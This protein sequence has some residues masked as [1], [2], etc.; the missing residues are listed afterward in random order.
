[1]IE[2]YSDWSP[3]LRSLAILASYA[4]QLLVG[5][6]AG[7]VALGAARAGQWWI[8]HR[9][10]WPFRDRVVATTNPAFPLYR[11]RIRV[12]NRTSSAAHVAMSPHDSMGAVV[13]GWQVID[14]WGYRKTGILVPLPPREWSE[15]WLEGPNSSTGEA[16]THVHFEAWFFTDE[17]PRTNS[18]EIPYSN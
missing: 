1:M 9:I 4:P 11:A 10:K 6:V 8:D 18:A 16:P 7:L 2:G 14:P 15:Y 12:F 13:N 5:V 17:R 3:F